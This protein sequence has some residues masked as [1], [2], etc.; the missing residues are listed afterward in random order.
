MFTA[1]LLISSVAWS[2]VAVVV[3][4][5]NTNTMK[6]DD[7]SRLFLGKKKSFPDGSAA[8]PVD[9]TAGSDNRSAFSTKVLKKSDRQT[10][11]YWA[12]LLFTGRGTPPKEVGSSVDVKKLIA[13]D[14]SLIGYID[15]A[16]VDTS[17]K[18]VF[19]F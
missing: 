3:H 4:P 19:Q 5:N 17:V 16:D 2:G 10:K 7:I 8:T 6:A 1:A 15:S 14:P 18:I 13:Q 12:Q 9:Q 11:S